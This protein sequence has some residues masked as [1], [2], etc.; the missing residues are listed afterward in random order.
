MRL[1]QKNGELTRASALSQQV[2]QLYGQGRYA[3]AIP[4]A[5]ETLAILEKALGPDHPDV[6]TSLNNM[7]ELYHDQGRYTEA[8]P[9]YKCSLAIYEKALGPDHTL[10]ATTLNGTVN[11]S[12]AGP[13]S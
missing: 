8:E 10:V 2:A 3:D 7:A 11:L 13:C 5:R 9:L 6:A 4:L 1:P 12:Q